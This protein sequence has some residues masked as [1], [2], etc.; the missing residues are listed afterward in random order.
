MDCRLPWVPV[1]RSPTS[2]S[3]SLGAARSLTT[4]GFVLNGRLKA[5]R[6][7]NRGVESLFQILFQDFQPILLD[8][9][10]LDLGQEH[11]FLYDGVDAVADNLDDFLRGVA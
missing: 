9:Q 5:V 8:M 6:V 2:Q 1:A 11:A 3:W 4:V 7:D 10:K